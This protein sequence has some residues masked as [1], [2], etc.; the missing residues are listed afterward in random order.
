MNSHILKYG[1]Y[2]LIPMLNNYVY[3]KAVRFAGSN[4][5]VTNG[6]NGVGGMNNG[7]EMSS[8]RGKK[9]RLLRHLLEELL[10]ILITCHDEETIWFAAVYALYLLFN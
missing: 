8:P 7:L 10:H 9:V 4:S 6:L 5:V 3:T 2:I 1:A